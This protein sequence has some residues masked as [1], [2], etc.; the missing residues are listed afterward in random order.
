MKK[1]VDKGGS[2]WYY[3]QA[4]KNGG[5]AEKEARMNIEN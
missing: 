3:R 1:G 5:G 4:P 2:V